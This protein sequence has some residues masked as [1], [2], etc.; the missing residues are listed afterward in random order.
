M[1]RRLFFLFPDELHAR[2]TVDQLTGIGIPKSRI[3][4]MNVDERSG[5]LSDSTGKQVT[6]MPLRT[7][8][9]L[10]N[11]NLLVFALAAVTFMITLAIGELFWIVAAFAILLVSIFAG[12]QFTV[13]IPD[14][15]LAEF[16]EA[17]KH[18][19]YL[20]MAD[21]KAKRVTEVEDYV[22]RRHPEA[23][24]G[25]VNWSMDAFGI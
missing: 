24:V 16:N 19:G 10:W 3:Q 4:V 8:S 21:V 14:V 5:T 12:K 9:I 7:Q 20:L 6:R 25:G 1:L 2:S 18:G 22:H 13:H 17:L 11:V 15:H 23:I